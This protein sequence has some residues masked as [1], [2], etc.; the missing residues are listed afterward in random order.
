[1]SRMTSLLTAV[2]I[3]LRAA[4][5]ETT[6]MLAV[7]IRTIAFAVRTAD[8][9]NIVVVRLRLQLPSCSSWGRPATL[10]PPPCASWRYPGQGWPGPHKLATSCSADDC[11]AI[12]QRLRSQRHDDDPLQRWHRGGACGGRCRLPP[13]PQSAVRFAPTA[14]G[15]LPVVV[16]RSLRARPPAQR[17]PAAPLP[18]PTRGLRH[19]AQ[20]RPCCW[21]PPHPTAA[22]PAPPPAPRARLQYSA[23]VNHQ[24]C[25]SAC[26]QPGR[27]GASGRLA[28]LA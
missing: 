5:L 17:R 22:P 18:R 1:M 27:E 11:G 4:S 8:Y 12:A 25:Q 6:L 23:S 21:P 26:Q 24:S 13:P 7:R 16:V 9:D 15:P 28:R 20:R 3:V 10:R 2:V 14:R 19:T